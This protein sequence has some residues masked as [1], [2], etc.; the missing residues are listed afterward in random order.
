MGN[1]PIDEIRDMVTIGA[2]IVGGG[3]AFFVFLQFAPVLNLRVLSSWPDDDSRWVLLRLEIENK[4]RVRVRKRAIRLQVLEYPEPEGGSLSE[5]V[6]FEEDDI[7]SSEKPLRWHE[8]IEI[9][10][11]TQ[12][13]DPGDI[14]VIERLHFCP[15][16]R[17]LGMV[18][19]DVMR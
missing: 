7:I 9:F 3:F 11:S 6:P 12:K 19:L 4:S 17:I 18:P 8:P 5:W 1:L 13:I 10:R 15:E 2:L 16:N 14:L